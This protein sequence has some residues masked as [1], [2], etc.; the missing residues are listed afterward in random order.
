MKLLARLAVEYAQQ[1]LAYG[2]S[3]QKLFTG[4]EVKLLVYSSVVGKWTEVS[5]SRENPLYSL[6][7]ASQVDPSK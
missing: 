6:P 1:L 4:H 2:H 7:K 5:D 3:I